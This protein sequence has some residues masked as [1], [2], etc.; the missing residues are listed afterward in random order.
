MAIRKFKT[1][2]V[3]RV[4]YLLDNATV[5]QELAN[6]TCEGPDCKYFRFCGHML[7]VSITQLCHYRRKSGTDN[8]K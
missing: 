2:N 3:A 1:I 8:S 5:E 7:S 6:V 4:I